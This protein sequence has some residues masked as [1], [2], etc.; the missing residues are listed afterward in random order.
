MTDL[1]LEDDQPKGIKPSNAL[2]RGEIVSKQF[3]RLG[4]VP[5]PQL[6]L[7][8]LAETPAQLSY[9]GRTSYK[10]GCSFSKYLVGRL[11]VSHIS[12]F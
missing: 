11:N 10:C 7:L 3:S 6:P 5:Q 12:T 2:N 8:S 4:Q 1:Y 9:G